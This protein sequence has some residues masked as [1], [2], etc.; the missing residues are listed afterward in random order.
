MRL[1][2]EQAPRKGS[3]EG[4]PDRKGADLR[5]RGLQHQ[6]QSATPTAAADRVS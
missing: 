1:A 2:A 5:Q 6:G 3:E 4:G